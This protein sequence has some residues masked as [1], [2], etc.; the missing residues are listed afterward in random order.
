[1]WFF[2][3]PFAKCMVRLLDRVV[4]VRPIYELFW[5]LHFPILQLYSYIR[6]VCLFERVGLRIEIVASN[7]ACNSIGRVINNYFGNK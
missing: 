5:D 6:F 7:K 1:M 3:A 2:G 4:M